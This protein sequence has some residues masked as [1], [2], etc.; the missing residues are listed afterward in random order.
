MDKRSVAIIIA[1]YNEARRIGPVIKDVKK[2]GWSNVIVVDDGSKDDTSDVARKAGATVLRHIINRGQGAA[3]RTGIHYALDHGSHAVVTYD[4]DGQFVA[5]DIEKIARPVMEARR[6]V[7]LGSRFL[8]TSSAQNITG[9]KRF[10]LKLGAF[11]TYIFSGLKLSDS[12]NGFRAFS[13]KAAKK[14]RITF[15]RME[16][17]SEITEEI[18]KHKLSYTEVPVTVIYHEAGQHP[19]R[20]L[21]MGVKLVAKK[22]LGW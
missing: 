17:A 18:A 8:K 16:H 15:D 12:H 3:L 9:G 14:I 13:R 21:K 2:H 10:V 19:I 7:T 11:V 1:A 4:A 22:V 6:D 20:S 5:S